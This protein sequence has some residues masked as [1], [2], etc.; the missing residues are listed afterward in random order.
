M[1]WGSSLVGEAGSHRFQSVV[2][3]PYDEFTQLRMKLG[4]MKENPTSMSDIC[5]SPSV[6]LE[7]SFNLL[8]GEK[9]IKVM[10]ASNDVGILGMGM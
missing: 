4:F 2:V 8:F 10:C 1:A 9:S 3:H 7:V 6:F 5:L